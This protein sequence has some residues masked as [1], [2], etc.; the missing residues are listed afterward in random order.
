LK[1]VST[2]RA[3]AALKG[4]VKL[5]G[6]LALAIIVIAEDLKTPAER[7]ALRDRYSRAAQC[8]PD[9]QACAPAFLRR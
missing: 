2:T 5:L 7:K 3:I 6:L 9:E 4:A 1:T 8:V